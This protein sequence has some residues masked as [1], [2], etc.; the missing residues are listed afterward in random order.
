MSGGHFDYKCFQISQFADELQHEIDIND[1][2]ASADG[3][4]SGGHNLRHETLERVKGVY[5]IIELAGD[6]AREVEW[7]Y[8]GDHGETTFNELVDNLMISFMKSLRDG[9][10]NECYDECDEQEETEEI[11]S[12]ETYID[13]NRKA[14]DLN[15]LFSEET[16]E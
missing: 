5:N 9:G 10:D 8:S 13:E 7:L 4:F 15:R 3:D 12:E 6:L 1:H 16:G 14:K 2:E 11:P